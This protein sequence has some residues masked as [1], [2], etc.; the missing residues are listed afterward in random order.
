[1]M[2]L[3]NRVVT[4]MTVYADSYHGANPAYV[5]AKQYDAN[6]RFLV[7]S[8]MSSSGKVIPS[9]VAQLNAT[10]ADGTSS[11]INGIIDDNGDVVIGLTSQVLAEPGNVT[12]DI[13]VFSDRNG[14]KSTVTTSSFFIVVLESQYNDDAIQSA[15]EFSGA[16]EIL[17]QMAKER[18]ATEDAAQYVHGVVDDAVGALTDEIEGVV[19]TYLEE[20]VVDLSNIS[21]DKVFFPEDSHIKIT[22]E[23][24]ELK[25]PEG[26]CLDVDVS[27]KSLMEFINMAAT[28]DKEPSVSNPSVTIA[29]TSGNYEVGT[30][31]DVEYEVSFDRG[32]YQYNNDTGVVATGVLVEDSDGNESTD[33]QGTIATIQVVD[34]TSYRVSV[35]VT[36]G[37]GDIPSTLLGNECVDKRIDAGTA[38]AV[39]S[40]IT[41]YRN[42][43]YGTTTDKNPLTVETIKGLSKS[44]RS[45]S[46]GY[47]LTINVPVGAMRVVFAYPSSLRSVTSVRDVN[48]LNAEIKSS[49]KE[50]EILIGGVEDFSPVSYRLYT[51]EYSSAN[52]EAN[53]YTVVI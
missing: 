9:G 7:V 16:Q 40:K 12:C 44:G 36:Y 51:I 18:Q 48:G 50:S 3:K 35:T 32:E 34:G 39:S 42:T 21:A 31:I 6:S 24:G 33:L 14:E 19:D 30:T 20:K 4:R 5:Y 28:Q 1:M 29:A 8:I 10:K 49:F 13:T 2:D 37:Q 23:F 46:N 38:S 43:Y 53:K 26:G 22:S 45:L 41:G 15:T 17:L 27:G 11:F 47:T 25:A 52:D